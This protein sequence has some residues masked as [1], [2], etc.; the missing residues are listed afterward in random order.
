MSTRRKPQTYRQRFNALKAGKARKDMVPAPLI[1]PYS[2]ATILRLDAFYGPYK[3]KIDAVDAALIAQGA[4][5]H[6]VKTTRRKAELNI[7]HFYS[8]MQNAIAREVF[9]EE[10]S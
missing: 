2:A 6:L 9:P 7:L 3:I 5:T 8:A 4:A 10:I 1:I